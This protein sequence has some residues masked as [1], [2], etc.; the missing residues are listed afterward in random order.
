VFLSASTTI[1]WEPR[2][3]ACSRRE[4]QEVGYGSSNGVGAFVCNLRSSLN[5]KLPSPTMSKGMLGLAPASEFLF[6]ERHQHSHVPRSPDRLAF[7]SN[8]IALPR[9]SERK[10]R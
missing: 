4:R 2:T 7:V 3:A 8:P 5:S 6:P 9:F 10:A 1:I